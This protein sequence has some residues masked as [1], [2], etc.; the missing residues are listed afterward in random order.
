LLFSSFS[1]PKK[2]KQ[3]AKEIGYEFNLLNKKFLPFFEELFVYEL[4][5]K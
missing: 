1:K 2:I 5:K 4:I 3:T